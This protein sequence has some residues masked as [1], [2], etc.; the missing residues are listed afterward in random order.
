MKELLLKVQVL[1]EKELN[2]STAIEDTGGSTKS[3]HIESRKPVWMNV[4][5]ELPPEGKY[6]EVC[7]KDGMVY[8]SSVL[9]GKFPADIGWW[10]ELPELPEEV[11]NNKQR[12]DSK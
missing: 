12:L 2:P 3:I 11:M 6:V 10:K 4:K 1:E 9:C 5:D 7:T 8:V